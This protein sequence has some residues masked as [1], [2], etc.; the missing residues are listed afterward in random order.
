[1]S[2]EKLWVHSPMSTRGWR[3]Y[4]QREYDP[5]GSRVWIH[6]TGT[7]SQ[8]SLAGVAVDESQVYLAGTTAGSLGG[9]NSGSDDAYVLQYSQSPTI[10]SF[11]PNSG[12]TGTAVIIR[13]TN[14]Y[15]VTSV[16]FNN[17]PASFTVNS[18]TQLTATLPA[19]ASTG[20]I[21]VTTPYGSATSA[22][23]FTVTTTPAVTLS[24]T[25][26]TRTINAGQTTTYDITISRANY[27]GSV[28]FSVSGHPTG[29]TVTF[30]N[31]PT[32]SS[33]SRLSIT[34]PLNTTAATYNLTIRG[35]ATGISIPPVVVTLR[36]NAVS[37][38]LTATPTSRTVNAG[39]TT[40]YTI[41][42]NRTNFNGSVSLSRKQHPACRRGNVIQPQFDHR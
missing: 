32:T 9:S 10:G 15:S 1:M 8:D 17:A 23:D 27:P 33:F 42:I 37:V 4:G 18:A 26:A 38:S 31:N 22:T 16:T 20:R 41:N 12:A 14:Y 34:P 21:R 6:Q 35:S 3:T 29:S 39:Q 13:G 40:T 36:V 24:V 7:T 2:L 30:T 28:S 25:P 5:Q 11:T 19:P